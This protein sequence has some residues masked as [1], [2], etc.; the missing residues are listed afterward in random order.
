MAVTSVTG[1]STGRITLVANTTQSFDFPN[2]TGD[3]VEI[4]NECPDA[5]YFTIGIAEAAVDPTAD[6][7]FA[8]GQISTARFRWMNNG[9]TDTVINLESVA[10]GDICVQLLR[11][12]RF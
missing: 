1:D 11:G 3:V 6:G 7:T 12:E 10:G 9:P 4:V 5:V 8:V 2:R